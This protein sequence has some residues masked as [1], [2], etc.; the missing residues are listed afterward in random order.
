[1][2]DK[3]KGLAFWG[4]GLLI[5]ILVQASHLIEGMLRDVAR[6][7]SWALFVT[8]GVYY[9]RAKGYSRILGG[10]LGLFHVIG[11]FILILLPKR[12]RSEIVPV[13]KRMQ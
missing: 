1:M 5:P 13:E 3:Q 10:L 4:I 7:S 11:A 9:A 6:L 8:G 12:T 2:D